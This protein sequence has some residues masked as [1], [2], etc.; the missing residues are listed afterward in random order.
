MKLQ[1]L[2]FGEAVNAGSN[3]VT[4]G[5]LRFLSTS[6]ASLKI[7]TNKTTRNQISLECRIKQLF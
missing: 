3:H 4:L 6:C 2:I 7:Q 1:D 5:D